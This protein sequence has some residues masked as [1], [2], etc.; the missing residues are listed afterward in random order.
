[1]F[2]KFRT[3]TT[4]RVSGVGKCENAIYMSKIGIVLERDA[5]YK[6]YHVKF[7]D[8]SEDWFDEKYLR[9]ELQ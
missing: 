2:S 3:N 4:V 8:G 1:M 9:K 7:L 6:D 5:Y